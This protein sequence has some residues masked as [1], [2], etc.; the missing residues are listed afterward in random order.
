MRPIKGFTFVEILAA[1]VFMALVIPTVIE[2]LTLANRTGLVAQ[3]K[4]VAT[5]LADSMLS[6]LVVTRQTQGSNPAGDFG[7]DHPGYRWTLKS[8]Q[9]AEDGSMR[10]VTIQVW[11]KVQERDYEVHLSTLIDGETT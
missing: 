9:W 3:R 11:Y 6:E 2:G 5:Q 7:A 1:M 4:R 10:L 8:E